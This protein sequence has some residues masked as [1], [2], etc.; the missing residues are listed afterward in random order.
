M[1]FQNAIT[2]PMLIWAF[3][4]LFGAATWLVAFLSTRYVD[5]SQDEPNSA[6]A[7]IRT[8]NL[9]LFAGIILILLS[10]SSFIYGCLILACRLAN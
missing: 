1:K 9:F 4:T 8:S 3:G 10:L 6:A 2:G 7:H 5:K